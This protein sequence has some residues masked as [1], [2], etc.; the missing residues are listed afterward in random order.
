MLETRNKTF[1]RKDKHKLK[2]FF[3]NRII[4]S[5]AE[6]FSQRSDLKIIFPHLTAFIP[7]VSAPLP[8]FTPYFLWIQFPL[9]TTWLKQKQR[10]SSSTFCSLSSPL[11]FCDISTSPG[12]A[13]PMFSHLLH[14]LLLTAPSSPPP[15]SSDSTLLFQQFKNQSNDLSFHCKNDN[16]GI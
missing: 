11:Y 10:A 1:V 15:V 3:K 14:A 7:P 5:I 12:C 6:C 4:V 2:I 16:L 9:A 8:P 13:F